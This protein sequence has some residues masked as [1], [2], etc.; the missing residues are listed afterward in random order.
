MTLR[1]GSGLNPATIVNFESL[2]A[3][4]R[5][6][7]TAG[8][9]PRLYDYLETQGVHLRHVIN[10]LG[11]AIAYQP[12]NF[13]NRYGLAEH[14]FALP[15]LEADD[16]T[17][18]DVVVCSMT[19]SPTFA[20][21]LKLGGVLGANAVVNAATYAGGERCRLVRTPLRW[22]QAG[23]VGHACVLDPVLARPL[24]DQAP[25]DLAAE[26]LSHAHEL[27]VTDAVAPERLVIPVEAAA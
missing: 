20:C 18:L 25:G 15:V 10:L 11:G 14:A 2:R 21:L 27:I 22:L 13:D 6:L 17:P 5:L 24:L 16:E 19:R 26:D 7:K 9:D 4:G 23:I 3:Y 1:A 8:P 12:Y